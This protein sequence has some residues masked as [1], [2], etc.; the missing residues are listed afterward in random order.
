MKRG[1]INAINSC[2][3]KTLISEGVTENMIK[4]KSSFSYIEV[5]ITSNNISNIGRHI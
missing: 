1:K 4:L 2:D 5:Q 3:S